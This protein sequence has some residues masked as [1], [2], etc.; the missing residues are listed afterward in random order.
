MKI[1]NLW[2]KGGFYS[3]DIMKL[4]SPSQIAA[5]LNEPSRDKLEA[6]A[7][8]AAGLTRQFFGRAVSLYTPLYIS[9]HCSSHC[10]YCGFH[11]H[12][13]IRRVKLTPEQITTESGA[14]LN[15]TRSIP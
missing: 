7:R 14:V 12:N 9:N 8:E 4:P 6:L 10:T 11:C 1:E 5:I 3:V 13:K 15:A 2:R